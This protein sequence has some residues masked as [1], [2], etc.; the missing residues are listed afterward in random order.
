MSILFC[1]LMTATFDFNLERG[2]PQNLPDGPS[3]FWIVLAIDTKGMRVDSY[4]IFP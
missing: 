4:I 2:S 1:Q 3:F